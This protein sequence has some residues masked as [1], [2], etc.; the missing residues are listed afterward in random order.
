MV[1]VALACGS[2]D[3]RAA[4]PTASVAAVPLLRPD[5]GQLFDNESRSRWR[6]AVRG[7]RLREVH[8]RVALFG[9]LRASRVFEYDTAGTLLRVSEQVRR[10]SL[11]DTTSRLRETIVDFLHDGPALA[12]RTYHGK[13]MEV[14]RREMLRL[15][16]RGYAL[17]DSAVHDAISRTSAPPR[18]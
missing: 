14:S 5:S 11:D 17:R 1:I 15:F 16:A 6:S 18:D 8:E 13:A 7:G 4:T 3:G 2:P 12:A 9:D 10:G